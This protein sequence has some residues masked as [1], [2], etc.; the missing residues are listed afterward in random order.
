L[1]KEGYTGSPSRPFFPLTEGFAQRS[2]NSRVGM[3]GELIVIADTRVFSG[4]DGASE[5]VY[6]QCDAKVRSE[7]CLPV[8]RPGAL[9][10]ASRPSAEHGSGG[11]GGVIGIIDA[12][13]WRPNAYPVPS[14]A[15]F[16]EEGAQGPIEL[17]IAACIVL[18]EADLLM[19]AASS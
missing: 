17:L 7:A 12:E 11:D 19:P 9:N 18:G 4:P 15:G 16:T 6:Y 1:V 3:Y 2:N 13:C 5:D 8:F 10:A 14:V